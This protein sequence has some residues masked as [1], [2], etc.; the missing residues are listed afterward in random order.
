[1]LQR[2][3]A[4]KTKGVLGTEMYA[5]DVTK[6]TIDMANSSLFAMSM[7]IRDGDDAWSTRL[8]WI[9]S[10]AGGLTRR[11]AARRQEDDAALR[12]AERSTRPRRQAFLERAHAASRKSIVAAN[13]L[14][15]RIVADDTPGN[16]RS[17]SRLAYG[18]R[19][20]SAAAPRCTRRRND[21]ARGRTPSEPTAR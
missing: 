6:S 14:V 7:P 1:M 18:H 11:G 17:R 19:N 12:G 3:H 9:A 21:Q 20:G 2:K 4:A 10:N 8:Q 15:A 5:F 13:G 16:I